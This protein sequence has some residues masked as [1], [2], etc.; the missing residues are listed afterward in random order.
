MHRRPPVVVADAQVAA[1]LLDRRGRLDVC[2]AAALQCHRGHVDPLALASDGALDGEVLGDLHEAR[3]VHVV[4]QRRAPPVEQA[5]RR[6]LLH[7]EANHL[8]LPSDERGPRR[9]PV[10][11]AEVDV[12]AIG[13]GTQRGDVARRR[14]LHSAVD[15]VIVEDRLGLRAA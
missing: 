15:D 5:V 1:R 9:P 6:G 10:V 13:D 14:R 8:D 7:Q 2:G 3:A 11:V 12:S 4:E